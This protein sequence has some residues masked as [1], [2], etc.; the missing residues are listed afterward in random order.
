MQPEGNLTPY[1]QHIKDARLP[2]KGKQKKKKNF[3]AAPP[4]PPFLSESMLLTNILLFK[5]N[6]RLTKRHATIRER[7]VLNRLG[8]TSLCNATFKG[9]LIALESFGIF[10][11][12]GKKII[13]F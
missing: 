8:N 5:E 11:A 1:Q 3:S 9:F 12:V 13:N 6:T 2:A 10:G 7:Y 4:P